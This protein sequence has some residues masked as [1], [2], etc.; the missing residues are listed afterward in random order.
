[1]IMKAT[2]L[3]AIALLA[4]TVCLGLTSCSKDEELITLKSGE[5]KSGDLY[6]RITSYNTVEVFNP[7]GYLYK[8][9]SA[10]IPHEVKYKGN[11]YRVT[12]IGN[13]FSDQDITYVSIPNSVTT[14]GQRAFSNCYGLTSIELPNSVTTIGQS[15]FSN[16]YGLTSVELANSVTKI[17]Q[18]AFIDCY[19]L[20]SINIPTGVTEIGYGAFQYCRKLIIPDIPGTVKKI[21][22][23]AFLSCDYSRL[24]AINIPDGVTWIGN[25]AFEADY[26]GAV[27]SSV[28]S[29]TIPNS[30]TN[31]CKGA[32]Y[33]HDNVNTIVL[34][35]GLK[36]LESAFDVAPNVDLN[37]YCLAT[38]PPKGTSD[39]QFDDNVTV[40]IPKGSKNS[41]EA[42]DSDWRGCNFVELDE[43][44]FPAN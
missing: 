6:Y 4:M 5:F 10:I 43:E 9:S 25:N 8:G 41:Y 23:N 13:A 14:I 33:Y 44:D 19:N 21:G 38:T 11:I 17:G 18:W 15:A 32:F 37:V 26:I 36:V 16:C 40:Y 7:N 29:I 31:I 39:F 42:K 22:D 27:P 28:T 12:S 20:K 2:R 24:S 35:K 30:V 1:M 34:G 3:Y